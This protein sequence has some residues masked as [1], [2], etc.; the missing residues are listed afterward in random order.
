MLVGG[1]C[2]M[3]VKMRMLFFRCEYVSQ[4]KGNACYEGSYDETLDIQRRI[5][6]VLIHFEWMLI[7]AILDSETRE[8]AICVINRRDTLDC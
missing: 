5:D 8:N 3:K 7:D 1:I 6:A 4:Q 2:W